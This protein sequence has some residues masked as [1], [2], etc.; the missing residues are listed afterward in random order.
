MYKKIALMILS[1][2][3]GLTA[4]AQVSQAPSDDKTRLLGD[5]GLGLFHTGSINKGVESSNKFLPYVNATY[6][7]LF[8]RVDTFGVK[9]LPLA[10]GNLEISTRL[11]Q[12]GF[13]QAGEPS[14]VT[15]NSPMPV[16]IST[17]QI[18]PY[19]AFFV[20]GF[21]DFKSGGML[22]DLN[23]AARFKVDSFTL[24]P[25]IGLEQRSAKYVQYL[26]GV[27]PQEA[28]NSQNS[29]SAFAGAASTSP[30]IGLAI[31]YPIDRYN[32]LKLNLRKK[33]LDRNISD[34][35]LVSATSQT[36]VFLAIAHEFH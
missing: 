15:R 35:P 19:G 31:D 23:Y 21:H 34:S 27:T 9:V 29:L 10:Y 14:S 24:Y 1:A 22:F 18:T 2:S 3:L 20:H 25:Q 6:G 33:W 11:G 32:S 5:V 36:N 8:A 17:A 28:V 7:N 16:G 4:H 26:Y 12:E 13:K 30:K